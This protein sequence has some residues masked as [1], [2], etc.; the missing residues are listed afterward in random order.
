MSASQLDRELE[1]ALLSSSGQG[2]G[3]KDGGSDGRVA[4]PPRRPKG[5]LGLLVVLL[6]MAGGI[7]ALVM[8]SF[9]NAA[10]Y[11]KEVDQLKSEAPQL[12]GRRLRVTGNLVHGSLQ[13]RDQP[14]E[15]RFTIKGKD[16]ELPVRFAK[17][18]VPD[19]FKDVPDMDVGVT[20]EG[21]LASNGAF[22]ATEIAAK[23]PSKYEMKERR[24]HG[25]KMPHQLA[26]VA[27]TPASQ[28]L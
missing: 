8:T 4:P 15:Y 22:D 14:C 20:V 11:A 13:R 24:D 6:V 19:T 5:N 7:V 2:K 1:R 25:E 18:V 28:S 3:G 26:P 12:A 9:N 27:D 23:C 21:K 16:A 10:V 17:C